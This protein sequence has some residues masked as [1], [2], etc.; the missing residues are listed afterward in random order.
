MP[1]LFP[2]FPA[3]AERYCD[4]K[5]VSGGRDELYILIDKCIRQRVTCIIYIQTAFGW[6]TA[7]SSH[8][9]ELQMLLLHTCMLRRLKRDVLSVR[10]TLK[11]LF[12]L[13]AFDFKLYPV[14]TSAK[15]SNCALHSAESTRR[16]HGQQ[17]SYRTPPPEQAKM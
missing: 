5:Q 2:D 1:R 4:A 12:G 9:A 17:E 7:G 13:S 16:A 8:A 6:S 15:A 14:G 11:C 10:P 3:F